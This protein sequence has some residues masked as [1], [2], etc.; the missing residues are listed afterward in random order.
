MIVNDYVK[1]AL[2]L[3]V[4]SSQCYRSSRDTIRAYTSL[5]LLR[6]D[7]NSKPNTHLYGANM[8]NA[9]LTAIICE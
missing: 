1:I 4:L 8:I 5:H 7:N 3:R 6:L 9:Y 2:E